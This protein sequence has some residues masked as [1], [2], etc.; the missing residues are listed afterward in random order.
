[1]IEESIV[2]RAF[3]LWTMGHA[4]VSAKELSEIPG[5]NDFF[6]SGKS[7]LE[8]GEGRAKSLLEAFKE[9]R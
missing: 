5:L 4:K 7:Y 2:E 3:G 1:M 9:G 8:L 6:T